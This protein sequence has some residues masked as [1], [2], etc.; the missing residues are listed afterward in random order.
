MAAI[1]YVLISCMFIHDI[2]IFYILWTSVNYVRQ[3][4]NKIKVKFILLLKLLSTFFKLFDMFIK[5][6]D[7]W[8]LRKGLLILRIY[9][10]IE[11][12]IGIKNKSNLCPVILKHV[13]TLSLLGFLYYQ[14]SYWLTQLPNYQHFRRYLDSAKYCAFAMS[15]SPWAFRYERVAPTIYFL[16]SFSLL[17]NLKIDSEI[18]YLQYIL[19]K[20]IYDLWYI[21]KYI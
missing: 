14:L 12:D 19:Y 20:K 13:S 7:L 18:L 6:K 15:L 9:K 5:M 10:H 4:F 8:T 1:R 16:L 3:S 17:E 21:T 11:W 2:N